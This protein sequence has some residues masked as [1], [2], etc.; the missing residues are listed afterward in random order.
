MLRYTTRIIH[1]DAVKLCSRQN[2]N[3]ALRSPPARQYSIAS[4]VFNKDAFAK[5]IK[6]TFIQFTPKPS[7]ILAVAAATTTFAT[8]LLYKA[9]VHCEA[10]FARSSVA[11]ATTTPPLDTKVSTKDQERLLRRGELTFGT[12]LGLCTG[13]LVKKVGKVF[14]AFV[15]TG[16]IF[17]QY[18]SQQGYVTI[19]WDRLE[20]GYNK[21]LDLDK[22]GRVTR[23][24]IHTKWQGFVNFLTNNIQFK[25][26]F[27]VGFYV[28][29][30]YG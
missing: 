11:T 12:F 1:N 14:A 3:N 24:D 19:H 18:L 25:S 22:D 10:A 29:V 6:P 27:L 23:R 20:S 2:L 30:R 7:K 21:T 28:G 17:L 8:P 16:F 9:P 26:T 5:P 15:G 4:K 13:Y